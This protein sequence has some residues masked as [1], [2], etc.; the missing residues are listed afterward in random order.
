MKTAIQLCVALFFSSIAAWGQVRI[1]ILQSDETLIEKVGNLRVYHLKGNVGLRQD[2]AIMYCDSAVLVQPSNTFDAYGNVRIVQAD[3]LRVNGRT[4]HYEG[5][6]RTF[7]IKDNVH[8]STPTSE[9]V[10]ESLKYNRNTSVA[11]FNTRSTMHRSGLDLTSNKGF[12]NTAKEVFTVRGNVI[13]EDEGFH[14]ETDTLVYYPKAN[15]YVFHGPSTLVRDSAIIE[16]KRG[17]YEADNAFLKLGQGATISQPKSFISADS[18]AFYL[19]TN[20]GQLLG[21]AFVADTTERFVLESAFID[22]AESPN[23]V[24]AWT[25]VYYRQEMGSDTLFAKGDTLRI[26]TDSTDFRTV[27]LIDNTLLYS[28]DFQAK[29]KHFFYSEESERMYLYPTPL[30]W[31][32]QNQ[33]QSDT[34][35]LKLVNRELDSLYLLNNVRI[36]SEAKDT[37]HYD[38]AKGKELEGAFESN[39]LKSIR[40]SGNAESIMHN[41]NESA[42][43]GTNQSACSWIT[44]TFE[45]GQVTKV[46]AAKGVEATYTPNSLDKAPQLLEGCVPN[47]DARPLKGELVNPKP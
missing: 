38:Q 6:S 40:L 32:Q 37:L 10:T 27:R 5:E 28:N 20:E 23:Y 35:V 13:A 8:L 39:R 44:L 17:S 36:V 12:Y 46:K 11:Q 9:L 43:T 30:L 25:P 47:F 45:E 7:T 31:S 19:K 26:R 15:S 41:F 24:D 4:L 29:T 33:F 14:L 18:I 34:A 2:V 16:C 42:L 21:N 1:S 3:T 22:Y